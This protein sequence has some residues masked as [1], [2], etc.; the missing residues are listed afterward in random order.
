MT[1]FL[2][3]L[4]LLWVGYWW[5]ALNSAPVVFLIVGFG[6]LVAI[7]VV[8]GLVELWRDGRNI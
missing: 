7:L 3:L 4:A 5:V 8:V 2:A 6:P 1:V